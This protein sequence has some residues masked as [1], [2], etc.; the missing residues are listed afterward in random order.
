VDEEIELDR[1]KIITIE[2]VVDRL[3]VYSSPTD[4]AATG[5]GMDRTR[6][7]D[8]VETALKLGGGVAIVSDVTAESPRDYLFSEHF[9]CVHCGISLARDR[10][11]H[12]FFQQ[13]A[14]RLPGLHRPGRRA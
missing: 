8:S 2:A 10:A 1:Y 6:L 9:A 14:R 4:G 3:I 5:G 13:P 11:A 12:L 7:A